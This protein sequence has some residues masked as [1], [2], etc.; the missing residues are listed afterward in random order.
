MTAKAKRIVETLAQGIRSPALLGSGPVKWAWECLGT[1]DPIRS[2]EQS[3]GLGT[4]V[5]R[6][7][8]RSL[9]AEPVPPILETHSRRSDL[10][11]NVCRR[12]WKA[13]YAGMTVSEARRLRDLDSDPLSASHCRSPRL[14]IAAGR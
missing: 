3:A 5:V 13:K 1:H 12:S 4:A 2:L 11:P 14:L 9:V 10:R 7:D 8:V 6:R